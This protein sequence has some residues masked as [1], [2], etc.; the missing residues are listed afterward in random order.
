MTKRRKKQRAT[1]RPSKKRRDQDGTL[2]NDDLMRATV[3]LERAKENIHNALLCRS[4]MVDGG[5]PLSDPDLCW[6]LAKYV[7]N[8]EESVKQLDNITHGLLLAELTEIP[9]SDPDANLTWK[10]LKGMRERLAHRFW[11]IDHDVVLDTVMNDFPLL[12]DLFDCLYIVP[13]PF[14]VRTG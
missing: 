9:F 11:E 13:E 14:N 1:H 6:A 10:N 8:T 7:E 12:D 3:W 2:G 5:A 4:R